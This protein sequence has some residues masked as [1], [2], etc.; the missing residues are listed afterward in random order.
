ML[1]IGFDSG[2]ALNDPEKLYL[3]FGDVELVPNFN[4]G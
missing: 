4:G 2:S 3:R 1:L